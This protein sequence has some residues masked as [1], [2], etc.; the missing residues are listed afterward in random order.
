M[1]LAQ[2]NKHTD[3]AED[4]T[5]VSRSGIRQLILGRY[6]ANQGIQYVFLPTYSPDLN[7]VELCFRHIKTL[8]KGDPYMRMA[9][10]VS[11][12]YAILRAVMSITPGDARCYFQA[13]E[14][15]N[16]N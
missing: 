15:M 1:S 8:M 14:Y 7:P 4:R 9:K 6:L 11:L 5:R 2:G 3:P 13:C 16:V 12:D 10:D